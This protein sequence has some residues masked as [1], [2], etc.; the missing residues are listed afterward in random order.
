[1]NTAR[2]LQK[3]F[4]PRPVVHT[5]RLRGL[6][7]DGPRNLNLRG[8]EKGLERAFGIDSLNPPQAVGS[9]RVSKWVDEHT[10]EHLLMPAFH[11]KRFP[12]A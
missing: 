4:K 1:M 9:V 6:I 5:V 8:L 12:S 11:T 3:Y 2:F 7:G 10:T